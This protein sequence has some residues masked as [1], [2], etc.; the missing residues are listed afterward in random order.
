VPAGQE[1]EEEPNQDRSTTALSVRLTEMMVDYSVHV[2]APDTYFV[3]TLPSFADVLYLQLEA[4][5]ERTRG[6]Q[7]WI[8]R[9]GDR[10]GDELGV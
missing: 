2:L 9:G 10:I 4:E 3:F 8:S 5:R 7:I 6:H 1:E